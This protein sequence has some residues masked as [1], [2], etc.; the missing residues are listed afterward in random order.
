MM[1]PNLDSPLETPGPSRL[2]PHHF[3]PLPGSIKKRCA[4][5]I[6]RASSVG[7]AGNGEP[8]LIGAAEGKLSGRS[9]KASGHSSR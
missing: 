5:K 1:G 4:S 2:R 9:G 7:D 8:E 3:P 6:P